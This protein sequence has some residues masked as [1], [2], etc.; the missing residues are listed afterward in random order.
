MVGYS[1]NQP[2][3]AIG[4]HARYVWGAPGSFRGYDC[5]V[6]AR[7][8]LSA[9]TG[10]HFVAPPTTLHTLK[11]VCTTSITALKCLDGKMLEPMQTE[12]IEFR[13][14]TGLDE[15]AEVEALQ[16]NIWA[17]STTIIYRNTPINLARS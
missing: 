7:Q 13:P 10:S 17:D 4:Q 6:Y 12:N 9:R 16:S 8:T 14:L 15:M 11:A 3:R 2:Y 5:D 1:G